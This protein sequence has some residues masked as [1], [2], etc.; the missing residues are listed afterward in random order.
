MDLNIWN[1]TCLIKLIWLFVFSGG[2]KNGRDEVNIQISV[3]FSI[4]VFTK[5]VLRKDYFYEE[6]CGEILHQSRLIHRN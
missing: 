1:T 2:T 5:S 6:S 4:N 3:K